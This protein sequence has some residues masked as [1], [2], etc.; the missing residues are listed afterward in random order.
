MQNSYNSEEII[1]GSPTSPR[2]ILRQSTLPNP[3]ITSYPLNQNLLLPLS[4][5]QHRSPQYSPY[6][7]DNENEDEIQTNTL[8]QA[9]R[10]QS[11]LPEPPILLNAQQKYYGSVSPN[12]TYSRSPE[13]PAPM[14][15]QQTFPALLIAGTSPSETT[16][17]HIPRQLPTSPNKIGGV[18][19]KS[20]DSGNESDGYVKPLRSV[21]QR[22]VT[23]P[24]PD[25]Q[26]KV[27]PTSPP[28]ILSP[29]LRKVSPEFVRQNTVPVDLSPVA[30]NPSHSLTV[31]QSHSKFL[32]L[33]PRAK[34]SFMFSQ[35]Q[36]TPRTFLS[37]QHFPTMKDEPSTETVDLQRQHTKM[38]QQKR[39][40]SNEE[41]SVNRVP[42][43]QAITVTTGSATEC[44]RILPEIPP[45]RSP[46]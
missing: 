15:R 38:A 27:L 3:D 14:V 17:L 12:R 21:M 28:R 10:R 33:S 20:P 46:K 5:K 8:R 7:T 35:P 1:H 36:A 18:Y 30:N 6:H 2:R 42:S 39:S 37:Q 22:Q 43:N 24:N 40:F 32:P 31:H 11:T 29:S 16:L 34:Q 19:P 13:R 4:P 44:R 25:Y 41:P 45:N 26:L 9:I 23:L